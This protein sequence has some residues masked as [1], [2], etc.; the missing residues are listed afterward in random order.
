MIYLLVFLGAGFGGLS[1]FLV[2][3]GIKAIL[4]TAIPY[5]TLFVN[6]SGCFVMGWMVSYLMIRHFSTFYLREIFVIGFLGGYTTFSTFSIEALELL[7]KHQW[8][9]AMTYIAGHYILSIL[10]CGLGFYL[11]NIKV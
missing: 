2:S 8:G 5:A 11:G 9:N 6:L 1:R 3:N 4:D 10:F 7:M